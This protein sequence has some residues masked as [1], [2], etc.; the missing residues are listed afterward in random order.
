[1][2]NPIKFVNKNSLNFKDIYQSSLVLVYETPP[3]AFIDEKRQ[4]K[5]ERIYIFSVRS[6]C[7]SFS[8]LEKSSKRQILLRRRLA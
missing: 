5:Y 3:L 7:H 6:T 8:F 1:M 4:T 2:I